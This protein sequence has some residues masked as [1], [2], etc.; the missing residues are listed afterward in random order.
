MLVRSGHWFSISDEEQQ[1]RFQMRIH[2][3]M[4][5]WK[6]SEMD[7]QSRVGSNTQKQKRRCLNEL[8]YPKHHGISSKETTKKVKLYSHFR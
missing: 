6:L 8:P 4:K 2:D 5:Q 3:P 7:L 1:M